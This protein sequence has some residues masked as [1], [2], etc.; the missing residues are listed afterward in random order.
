MFATKMGLIRV[1]TV[2]GVRSELTNV[3]VVPGLQM[4]LLSVDK[5]TAKEFD[6]VNS[7]KTKDV[8]IFRKW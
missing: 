5:I 2:N 3:L 7:E 4:N 1:I 8:R 6:I